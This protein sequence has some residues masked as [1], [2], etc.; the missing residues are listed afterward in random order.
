MVLLI[1]GCENL[2]LLR[3]PAEIARRG[4]PPETLPTCRNVK[5][6]MPA[7]GKDSSVT[8][9]RPDRRRACCFPAA[10]FEDGRYRARREEAPND[11][12]SQ[13]PE[14]RPPACRWRRRL[15]QAAE[16][17]PSFLFIMAD[18]TGLGRPRLLW[19]RRRRHPR[20]S[21]S[22]PATAWFASRTVRTAPSARSTRV[23]L[24]DRP[25]SVP[26]ARRAR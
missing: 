26:P 4:K 13:R 23:G 12:S 18:D 7:S 19:T 14:G 6:Y 1:A 15:L 9:Y 20:T 21:T 3:R 24:I 2:Q 17:R 22:S 5:E 25:I 10:A 8:G 16:R 11:R